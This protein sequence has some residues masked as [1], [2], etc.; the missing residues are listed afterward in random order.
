MPASRQYLALGRADRQ[1]KECA[2]GK[3]QISAE[4]M[5]LTFPTALPFN[6]KLGADRKPTGETA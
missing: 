1:R 6:Y 3:F 5:H 4:N 2:V